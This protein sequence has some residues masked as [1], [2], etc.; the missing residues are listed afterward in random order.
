MQWESAKNA[1]RQILKFLCLGH[2]IKS[3]L[4]ILTRLRKN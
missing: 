4:E 2:P 3:L 1:E